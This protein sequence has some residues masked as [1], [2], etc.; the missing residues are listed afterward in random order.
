MVR[1]D[2]VS[3][4]IEQVR[5]SSMG[6]QK[7]LSLLHRLEPTHSSLSHPGRLMRLLRPIILVLFCTVDRVGA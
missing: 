5:H 1:P 4:K 7:S 3:A 6:T 2:R